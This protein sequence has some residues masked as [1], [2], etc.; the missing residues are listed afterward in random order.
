[1]DRH[2]DLA[3]VSDAPGQARAEIRSTLVEW[4]LLPCLDDALLIASELVTNAARHG[5]GKVKLHIQ[6]TDG[7]VRIEVEDQSIQQVPQRR[8]PTDASAGGRGL[9]LVEALSE[10]WGW[11]SG[12]SSKTVWAELDCSSSS[13][14]YR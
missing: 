11:D 14:V 3:A 9:I 6:A 5:Q 13:P 1:M 10:R 7:L 12:T 2:V 4:G 8:N